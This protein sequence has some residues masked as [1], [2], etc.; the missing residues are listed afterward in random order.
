MRKEALLLVRAQPQLEGGI[1]TRLKLILVLHIYIG[2]NEDEW[3][4]FID[5]IFYCMPKITLS[6]LIKAYQNS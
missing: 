4:N 3:S 1:M 5:Y 2:D 6:D